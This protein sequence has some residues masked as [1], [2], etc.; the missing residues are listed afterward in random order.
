MQPDQI[1]LSNFRGL[2]DEARAL[3]ADD[4]LRAEYLARALRLWR[5]EALAGLTSRWARRFSDTL[6]QLKLETIAEWADAELRG[7]RYSYAIVELRKALLDQPLA[8]ELHERLIRA[9]Y[10]G[11]QTAE[12]L[13]QY[14]RARRC[15]AD[16]LGAD[17]APTIR[18]LHTMIL[19]G[20][21]LVP[22]GKPPTDT[23]IV[24]AADR[25]P[26]LL[27]MDIL[28]FGGRDREVEWL[29]EELSRRADSRPV[30]VTGGPGVGKSALAVRTAHRVRP[31]FP[32]GCLYAD[33]RATN[34]LPA[35]PGTIL[36][37]FLRALGTPPGAIPADLDARA[38]SYRSRVA[39]RRILIVLDDAAD[40]E[41]LRLLL[42]GGRG[43]VALVTSR[44]SLS[45]AGVC[46]HTVGELSVA[47]SVDM[48]CR[49]MGRAR[50]LGER[51]AVE[52]LAG[53]CAGLPSALRI[54]ASRMTSRPHRTFRQLNARLADETRR[55]DELSF[56][57]MDVRAYIGSSYHRLDRRS[58][59]MFVHLGSNLRPG[60]V[61]TSPG[62]GF[63]RMIDVEEALDRLVDAHLLNVV[64]LDPVGRIQYSMLDVYRIY[65]AERGRRPHLSA[66]SRADHLQVVTN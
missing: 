23:R 38:E 55:L 42:P 61:T 48:L 52:E 8:E 37:R 18:K 33:L 43:S 40:E 51:D 17:L 10:L 11:G 60:E 66:A 20:R 46:R 28:D 45:I 29:N 64:G 21:P 50:V 65:A 32:D 36:T 26:D 57:S 31:A 58:A 53:Y 2:S 13:R 7:G 4:P 9:Y 25:A 56:G 47:N 35:N 41:Q 5:G 62:L 3:P 59:R 1:D 6:R 30:L 12:A 44:T 54:V 39:G 49:I 22:P 16:E 63:D 19:Q 15:I 34:A 27:P 24:S 14:D